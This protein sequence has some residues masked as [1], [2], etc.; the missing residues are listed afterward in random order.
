MII[1]FVLLGHVVGKCSGILE[2]CTAL[3]FRVTE[4]FQADAK[5]IWRLEICQLYRRV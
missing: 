2:E 1:V 3:N 5:A 4:L